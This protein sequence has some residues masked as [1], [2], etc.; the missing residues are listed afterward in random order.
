MMGNKSKGRVK[1]GRPRIPQQPQSGNVN[2][3]ALFERM[4]EQKVI[5]NTRL[6]AELQQA[7]LL[8]AGVIL[9]TGETEIAITQEALERLG[10]VVQ[11]VQSEDEA[12]NPVIAVVLLDEE[13]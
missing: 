11:L 12:G 2:M 3:A 7:Q 10:D 13:E 1:G 9:S 6:R 5:E 8:V 4:Y